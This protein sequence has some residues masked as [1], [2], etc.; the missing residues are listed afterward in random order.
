MRLKL[1]LKQRTKDRLLTGGVVLLIC[2]MGL[3]VA[4]GNHTRRQCHTDFECE[5]EQQV[6]VGNAEP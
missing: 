3:G 5:V 2:A 4:G 6:Q 1:K